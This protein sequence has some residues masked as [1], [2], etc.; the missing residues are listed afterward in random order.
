MFFI[1][2]KIK[3]STEASE[4]LTPAENIGVNDSSPYLIAIHVEPQI[5]QIVAYASAIL[6]PSLLNYSPSLQLL[7]ALC[8]I[9][10]HLSD[11]SEEGFHIRKYTSQILE[12]LLL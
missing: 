1:F 12:Y 11:K 10:D 6:I 4:N 5:K 7:Q 9:S 8:P 3:I 2:I